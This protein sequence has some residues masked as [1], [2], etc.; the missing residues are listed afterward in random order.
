MPN[1][2]IILGPVRL[3]GYHFDPP[4][5]NPI[6]LSELEKRTKT[7]CVSYR[8]LCKYASVVFQFAFPIKSSWLIACT[9]RN[10]V[11]A[12]ENLYSLANYECSTVVLRKGEWN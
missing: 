1:N 3:G 2:N 11:L 6:K 5:T 7:F 12:N 4:S 10:E 8:R 9:M